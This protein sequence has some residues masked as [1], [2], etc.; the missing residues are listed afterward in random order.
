MVN[1]P[2]DIVAERA[3]LAAALQSEQAAE[4]AV[5]ALVVEHFYQPRHGMVFAAI[6]DTLA[7]GGTPEV[8][9]VMGELKRRGDLAKVGDAYLVELFGAPGLPAQVAYYCRQV[10]DAWRLRRILAAAER[11]TQAVEQ[12]T[13]VDETMGTVARE[14]VDAEVVLD[15]RGWDLPV[16]GLHTWSEFLARPIQ[17]RDWVIPGLVARQD[18]VMILG[19]G[20][21]GKSTLGRQV[22]LCAAA[23]RHPFLWENAPTFAPRCTLTIDLENAED[24]LITETRDLHGHLAR[25]SGDLAERAWVWHKPG[26]L[27]LRKPEHAARLERVVADCQP[28]LI[29][30]GPMYKAAHFD[31]DWH[32]AAQETREVFDHIRERYKVGLWI[33]H[34]MPKPP[35]GQRVSGTPFGSAVWEWWTSVGRVLVHNPTDKRKPIY[36]LQSTFRADRG[37]HPGMPFALERG[38]PGGLPWAPIWTE[39]EYT[40]LTEEDVA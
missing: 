19:T 6:R 35:A 40:M 32:I 26:G 5:M 20:G 16:E 29:V 21:S 10:K 12:T 13:D 9:A 8:L 38:R 15:E 1:V 37:E 18:V 23:G 7:Q 36:A 3:V 34:H 22:A 25:K 30:V 17:D 11:M 39:E 2:Q 31:R 14:L 24:V 4:L 27:N 33:E 28:D